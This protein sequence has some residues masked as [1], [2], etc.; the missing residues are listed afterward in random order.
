VGCPQHEEATQRI[1]DVAHAHG[2]VAGAHPRTPEEAARRVKQ[3]F[4]MMSLGSAT[5]FMSSAARSAITTFR[6]A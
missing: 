1:L 3:G 2:L 5:G 4:D 6:N